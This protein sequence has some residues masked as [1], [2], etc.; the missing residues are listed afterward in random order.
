MMPWY[1]YGACSTLL[2]GK[3]ETKKK[4]VSL[5]VQMIFLIKKEFLRCSGTVR[6]SRAILLTEKIKTSQWR[7]MCGYIVVFFPPAFIPLTFSTRS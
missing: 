5:Y 1:L 3:R 4:I 2:Y 6:P 7:K